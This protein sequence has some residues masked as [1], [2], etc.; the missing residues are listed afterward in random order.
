MH[1]G[2]LSHTSTLLPDGRVLIT[3]GR[4]EKVNS[5]AEIYDPAGKTFTLT[6]DMITPRYK[7]AA[8]IVP[9]G[10][11]LV[12]G[13]SGPGDWHDQLA[14]AEIY[15]L[16]TGKFTAAAE[17]TGVRYKLPDEVPSLADGSLLFAGGS[18]TLD[19][20]DPGAKKFL[21]VA[22]R[23]PDARHFMSETKLADGAVLLTGGYPEDDKSTAAAYLYRQR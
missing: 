9:D 13:G 19:V 10:R 22:D 12:A 7:H 14:S 15:D 5:S 1:A 20:Y 21:P 11:V 2:R 4:G 3:G 8:G 6:G 16:G 17:L 23:L 18:R